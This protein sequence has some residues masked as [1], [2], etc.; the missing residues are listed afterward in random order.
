MKDKKISSLMKYGAPFLCFVLPLFLFSIINIL[1]PDKTVSEAENRNLETFP[2]LSFNTFFS[3]EFTDKFRVYFSDQFFGRNFWQSTNNIMMSV[4]SGTG[5]N[6]IVSME[7]KDDFAGQALN[8][9]P[10]SLPELAQIENPDDDDITQEKNYIIIDKKANRAMELYSK[11]LDANTGYADAVSKLQ[12]KA[13]NAQIYCLVAPTSVEF[14]SSNKYRTTQSS[15][16]ESIADIYTKLTNGVKSVDAYTYIAAHIDDYLYFRT[17]HHWTARGAYHA[18]TAFCKAAELTPVPL[19]EQSGRIEDFVGSLYRMTQNAVLKSNPDYVEYFMPDVAHNVKV[20]DGDVTEQPR[21]IPLISTNIVD[22]SM[23]YLAFLEGDHSLVQIDTEA[24][25]NKNL[26]ITKE[27]FGNSM[28]PFLINHY[29]TIYIIDPRKYSTA[30]IPKFIE[31]KKVD[32]VLCVNYM[33]V[34]TNKTF[35]TAFTKTIGE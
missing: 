6:E 17:D 34:P 15:Q 13:A 11:A 19:P 12:L 7:K 29:K 26:L 9:S 14:Y 30:N 22:S 21:E 1:V 10:D 32:D 16:K 5:K 20:W 4:Y 27:S 18:Y 24:V 28:V 33:F 8:Q 31:E 3:G 2:T 35:M 25:S 23:K